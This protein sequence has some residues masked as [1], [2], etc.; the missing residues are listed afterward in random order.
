[1]YLPAEL[2]LQRQRRLERDARQRARS[3]P[4]IDATKA[5]LPL[6]TFLRRQGWSDEEIAEY[7]GSPERRAKVAG[8]EAVMQDSPDGAYSAAIG[9]CKEKEHRF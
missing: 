7:E 5:G 8:M 1:M 2:L 3:A 9:G 4:S 6:S